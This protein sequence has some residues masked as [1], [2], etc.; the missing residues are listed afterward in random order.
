MPSVLAR[1][2]GSEARSRLHHHILQMRVRVVR[3]SDT[4]VSSAL[5]N[6]MSPPLIEHE[7]PDVCTETDH[8]TTLSTYEEHIH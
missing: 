8:D 6:V 7:A 3:Q 1:V 5:E 2:Q 4:T